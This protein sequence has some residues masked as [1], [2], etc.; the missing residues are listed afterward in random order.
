MLQ[1]MQRNRI[2]PQSYLPVRLKMGQILQKE[3][4][5]VNS[6]QASV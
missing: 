5:L 6:A 4:D 1:K 3:H 2:N